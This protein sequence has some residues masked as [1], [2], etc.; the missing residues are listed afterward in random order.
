MIAGDPGRLIV[1]TDVSQLE[2]FCSF[3]HVKDRNSWITALVMSGITVDVCI[4]GWR[5]RGTGRGVG[6]LY[7]VKT[8]LAVV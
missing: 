5:V 7:F 3:L 2:S 6:G 1:D 8:Y 4:R